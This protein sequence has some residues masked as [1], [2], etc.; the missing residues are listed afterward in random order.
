[1]IWFGCKK[2]G[3]RHGKA[4][5]LSGTLVFCECGFGN[6]VPWSSTVP[7]PETPIPPAVPVPPARPR[8]PQPLPEDDR[9]DSRRRR[10]IPVDDRDDWA[11]VPMRTRPKKE[12]RRINPNFCLVHDEKPS[13]HTCKDC[14]MRFCSSCIVTIQGDTLCGPCKNFRLRGTHRPA[15]IA[16][17]A[18]ISVIAGL[19]SAPIG[20]CLSG[21]GIT[22]QVGPEGGSGAGLF[23]LFGVV[24]MLLPLTGLV[25]GG[26]ALKQIESKPNVGGRFLAMTGAA[27][28]LVG[29]IWSMTVALLLVLK[30]F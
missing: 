27:A 6:R 15:V 23:L 28:G 8:A 4:E 1:M 17:L 18:I 14:G 24:G 20:F 29:T 30:L 16:P 7:E 5:S 13:E 22:A 3:K 25:L 12:A 26:L 19:I 21:T 11:P 10:S 2:C 9:P